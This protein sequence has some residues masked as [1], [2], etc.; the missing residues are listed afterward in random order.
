MAASDREPSGDGGTVLRFARK[1]LGAQRTQLFQASAIFYV[2]LLALMV[3]TAVSFM[4]LL[5]M[6]KESLACAQVDSP[7]EPKS[8]S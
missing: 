8:G 3:N 5:A 7:G 4:L 1:T 6:S 2:A